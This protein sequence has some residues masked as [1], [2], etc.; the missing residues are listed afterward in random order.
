MM[1]VLCSALMYNNVDFH[2]PKTFDVVMMTLF[3]LTVF[4]HVIRLT[5]HILNKKVDKK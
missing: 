4:I 2:Q 5:M 1:L 3:G